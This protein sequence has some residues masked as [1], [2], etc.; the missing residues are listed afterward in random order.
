MIDWL[1]FI[2]ACFALNL[3]FGP[4][5]LLA[6]THGARR[7]VGFA[8]LASLGRLLAFAPMIALSA[9][10]LGVIL[11]AS[12]VVFGIVKIIGAAYLIWLGIS[13]LR[14]AS[15]IDARSLS[16]G[17]ITL[18]RALRSEALVALSN[19][20]AILIFA[21]FF[22]QFISL[23]AYWSGYAMLGAAFLVLEVMAILVYALLGK[24]ASRFAAGGLPIFQRLSG[25][26]MCVFGAVL[27]F[28]PQPSPR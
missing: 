19:P 22:P 1:L 5:N 26:M 25:A 17:D 11:T 4:N 10:G 2:P 12:S 6:L 16:G 20:K 8:A 28:S 3:A 14:S 13:L 23:E 27:L 7:G 9:L 21:A 24:V 18:P 15:S